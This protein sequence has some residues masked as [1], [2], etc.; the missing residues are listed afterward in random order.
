MSLKHRQI[1][2][3]L[4]IVLCV[5][6]LPSLFHL[7]GSVQ[8]ARFFKS[9]HE[10]ILFS[11]HLVLLFYAYL[12]FYVLVP[13]FYFKN[14]Y[15][16]YFSIV[17]VF[18]LLIL[19]L[20]EWYVQHTVKFNPPKDLPRLPPPPPF[21]WE[22]NNLALF[23]LIATLTG[24][25][26]KKRSLLQ[27]YIQQNEETL[28]LL[29]EHKEGNIPK[30]TAPLE[31]GINVTVD[32]GLTRVDFAAILFVKSMDNYVQFYLKGK[33]NLLVRMT[34]KE[35]VDKLPAEQFVRV[36]KSYIVALNAIEQVRNKTITIGEH[37]IPL[38]PSFEKPFLST[39]GYNP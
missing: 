39:F 24:I 38:G 8:Y 18:L 35:V 30:T 28:R 11:R 23:F 9:Y 12:N 37:K 34:L 14:Q 1:I 21:A 22:I 6:F 7:P 27:Q 33:K 20:P 19:V 29:E 25:V 31:N 36:H 5:L 13:R 17:L 26:V 3:H 4:V 15:L 10:P 16:I 2:W 32:Y